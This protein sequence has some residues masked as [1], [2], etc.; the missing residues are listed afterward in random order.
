MLYSF[1]VSLTDS[2]SFLN[3][4]KY[5]TFRTGLSVVTS[6]TII[7]LIGSPLIRYFFKKTNYRTNKTRW[8]YRSYRKKKWHTYNGGIN[9]TYWNHIKYH[10]VG[11]FRKCLYL[12]CP[13]CMFELRITGI[14][15]RLFKNQI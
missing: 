14:L 5:I 2:F 1:L 12:D 4:F 3:V 15:R 7:F 10:Y 6:L 11:R 9:D 8:T 13:F